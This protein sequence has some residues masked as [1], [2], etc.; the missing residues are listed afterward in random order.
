MSSKTFIL[1]HDDSDGYCSA[2]AAYLIYKDSAVYIPVQYKQPFPDIVLDKETTIFVVDFSYSR[3]ILEDVAS[4]VKAI[5]VI[6]H[7]E[8]AK[9]QLKGLPYAIFDMEHSGAMLCWYYFHLHKSTPFIV[10]LVEDRDLWRFK[11]E[12]SKAFEA[13]LQATGKAKDLNFWVSLMNQ[14]KMYEV[15]ANGKMLLKSQDGYIKSFVN[16]GKYKVSSLVNCKVAVFNTTTLI[17]ELGNAI[18][19]QTDNL[20]DFT[21]SYF[22][23]K[24]GNV[25]FSLRAPKHNEV[26]VGEIAKSFGG[27]GHAKAAGFSMSLAE[28]LTF[29]QQ[30]Y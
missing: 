12:D 26:N 28:G 11:Y 16:S 24:E 27:G 30:F 15:I 22:I 29:L 8:T 4:K 10:Q 2:L 20:V 9:E 5:T 21:M 1:H 14:E 6:D 19:E 3:E 7:H 13:G 18:Y 17:S 23:S 25:I